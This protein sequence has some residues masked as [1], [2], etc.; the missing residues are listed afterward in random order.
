VTADDQ[1]R[2]YVLRNPYRETIPDETFR[3]L[4]TDVIAERAV[5]IAHRHGTGEYS[6]DCMSLVVLDPT[7]SAVERADDIVLGAGI[8]GPNGEDFLPN[9][10][11]KAFAH[12]DHRVDGGALVYT[13]SH[14]LRDGS[15][16]F[17]FSVDVDGTIVGASGQTELQDRYQATLLAAAFNYRVAQARAQWAEISGPGRWFAVKQVASSRFAEAAASILGS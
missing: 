17:G 11:A 16:R 6:R 12:R 10:I 3:G 13:Q 5:D 7:A 8:I 4:F 2:T 1:Y 9:A 15:F 14:R